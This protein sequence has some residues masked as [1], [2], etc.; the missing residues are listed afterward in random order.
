MGELT[1]V[2]KTSQKIRTLAASARHIQRAMTHWPD[3]ESARADIAVACS[4]FE[5]AAQALEALPDSYKPDL[6][7]HN[8]QIRKGT[9]VRFR[10]AKVVL[11]ED[12]CGD[13]A[14]E[15]MVVVE[16]PGLGLVGC[17]CSDGTDLNVPLCDIQV[18]LPYE[19]PS[20]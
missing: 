10:P 8:P 6:L 16:I 2:A 17:R 1:K 11:Y 5:R 7:R 19:E 20:S 14:R 9:L 12:A 18:A 13:V 3:I 15:T 4:K